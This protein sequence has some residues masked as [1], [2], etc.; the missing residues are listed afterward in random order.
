MALP[1]VRVIDGASEVISVV[2][3]RMVPNL[4]C[5][6]LLTRERPKSKILETSVITVVSVTADDAT[7]CRTLKDS[8]METSPKEALVES[9]TDDRGGE[10]DSF[11]RMK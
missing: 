3:V 5:P 9:A 2:I 7:D 8:A 6:L 4:F 1:S 10:V 11:V